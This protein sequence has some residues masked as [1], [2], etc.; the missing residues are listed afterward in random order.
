MILEHNLGARSKKALV[1][2]AG[3]W[4]FIVGLIVGLDA[5]WWVVFPI[6]VFTLPAIFEAARGDVARLTLD[7]EK[8]TWASS[9]FSGEAPLRDIDY[10]RFDTRLDFAINARLYLV[11]GTMLRL[12]VEC[13]PPYQ[14]FTTALDKAGVRHERHHFSFF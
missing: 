6:A 11:D 9:R 14:A 13:I 12:P 10:V 8:L 3:A 1:P 7:E 4:V 5:A 2:L